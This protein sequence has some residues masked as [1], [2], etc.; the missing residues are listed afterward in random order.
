MLTIPQGLTEETFAVLSAKVRAVVAQTAEDIQV[1][2]S[3]AAGTARP[4]SDLDIAI[5]VTPERFEEILCDRFG[6]PN[7][8]SEGENDAARPRNG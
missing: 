2:G 8:A 3:R 6:S 5:R 1:Q 4:D 7:A